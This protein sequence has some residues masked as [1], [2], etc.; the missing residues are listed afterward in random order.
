MADTNEKIVLSVTLNYSDSIKQTAELAS[1]ILKAKTN[2]KELKDAGK[3]GTAEYQAQSQAL[4]YLTDQHRQ[5]SKAIQDSIKVQQA[6]SGSI[7]QM[8]SEINKLTAEYVNLTKEERESSKGKD[9]LN[10][11]RGTTDEV[12]A[13]EKAMGDNRRNVGNYESVFASLSDQFKVGGINLTNLK[14]GFNATKDIIGGAKDQMSSFNGVMK[15][16]VIGIVITLVAGLVAAFSRF[17]PYVDKVEQAVGALNGVLDVLLGR[18]ITVGQG[19]VEFL[20]GNFSEGIDKIKHSFDGVGDSMLKAAKAGAELVAMQQKLDDINRE[21][22]ITNSQLNK[23]VDQ[24]LLKAKNRTLTERERIALLDEASAKEKQAFENNKKAAELELEIAQ[25]KYDKAVE[26]QTLNDAIEDARANAI[27]K[28]NQLE[29]DSINLQE[30][31]Q[32][33]RD[34]LIDAESQKRSA[35]LAKRLKEEE[36]FLKAQLDADAKMQSEQKEAEQQ[37]LKDREDAYNSANLILKRSFADAEK[38]RLDELAKGALT[39]QEFDNQQLIAREAQL[40]AQIALD[41]QYYK[42]TIDNEVALANAKTQIALKEA[43]DKK[44]INDARIEQ[45][46]QTFFALTSLASSLN[47][48]AGKNTAAAKAITTAQT[49]ISTYFT[50]QK[51]YESAFLPIPTIASPALGFISA[52][53]AVTAGLANVAKINSINTPIGGA[54][55][56]GGDFMTKGPTLLLVGDNPGGV[57][58]ISVEPIS[59]KGKTTINPNGNLVAMA[60]GGTLTAFG[61]YAERRNSDMGIIDYAALA[62]AFA[63]QPAPILRITDLN[64]VNENSSK[65]VAVSEL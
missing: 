17:Q 11:L 64:K 54:A 51:A 41:Q 43:A 23:E 9:L 47:E 6:N 40:E 24:L 34:S 16:N 28:V 50:A 1:E 29:S 33:R 18:L 21:N 61:G 20:S 48:L 27:A 62:D 5:Q 38:I 53:A 63:K 25:K 14:N 39:Q 42:D 35:A 55:A 12:K 7:Q 59:G 19:V 4:K 46:Q 36:D 58:R 30:K 13:L 22:I 45:E 57:E 44:A 2:I 52:A 3:E 65:V 26:N 32:N 37:A 56:G 10:K 8:R 31:I 60:G 15:A 49:L